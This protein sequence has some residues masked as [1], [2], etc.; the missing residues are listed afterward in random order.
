MFSSGGGSCALKLNTHFAKHSTLLPSTQHIRCRFIFRINSL[1][2]AAHSR[3]HFVGTHCTRLRRSTVSWQVSARAYIQQ[4]ITQTYHEKKQSHK[5]MKRFVHTCTH[6]HTFAH[7]FASTSCV[8]ISP[9]IAQLH[10]ARWGSGL[11]G[12]T[13]WVNLLV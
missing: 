6:T 2:C 4:T 7:T 12:T 11:E 9:K 3:Q 8:S 10:C 5:T 1:Q 13:F